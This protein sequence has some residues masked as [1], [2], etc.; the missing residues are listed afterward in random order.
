MLC[1]AYPPYIFIG[2][3]PFIIHFLAI[4]IGSGLALTIRQDT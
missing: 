4:S 3:N 2:A 1:D